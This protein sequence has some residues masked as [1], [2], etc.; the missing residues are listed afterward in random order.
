MPPFLELQV[1]EVDADLRI[2]ALVCLETTLT[3]RKIVGGCRINE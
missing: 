2:W 3:P 1:I